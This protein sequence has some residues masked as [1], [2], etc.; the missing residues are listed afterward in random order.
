MQVAQDAVGAIPFGE[1]T[2]EVTAETTAMGEETSTVLDVVATSLTGLV[3]PQT[4]PISSR[5]RFLSF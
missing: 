2:W 5:S 1:C 3:T 4:L